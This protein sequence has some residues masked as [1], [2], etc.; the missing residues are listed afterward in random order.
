MCIRDSYKFFT[1][2]GHLN[3]KCF[4]KLKV[5][6]NI[7]KGEWIGEIGDYKINGNWPPHLHFQ[8]MTS[9]L[10]EVDN[11]PGV[12][13][14]YLLKIWEQISP[15]PN[16]IL[17]IP[18]SFFSNKVQKEK[19]LLRRKKNIA[20]NLSISYQDPLHMLEAKGQFFY[21]EQGRRYLDCVNNISHVGHSNKFVHEASCTN[22]FE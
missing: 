4:K 10:N 17:Q 18:E 9:L 2:Y 3:K 7:K 15:D 22:L 5:G 11:F 20:R 14:D 19:I 8:I 13:E 21:D 6:Q 16:I 12:G 1:L